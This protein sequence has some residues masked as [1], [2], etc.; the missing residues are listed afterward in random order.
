MNGYDNFSPGVHKN[1]PWILGND[2][3]CNSWGRFQG[4]NFGI[5]CQEV[6]GEETIWVHPTGAT[7]RHSLKDDLIKFDISGDFK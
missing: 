7:A 4:R 5:S 2:F 1:Y 6:D 3:K